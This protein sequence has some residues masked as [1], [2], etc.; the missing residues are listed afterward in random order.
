METNISAEVAFGI[1]ITRLIP[2]IETSP[3]ATLSPESGLP[4]DF[5]LPVVYTVTA[6]DGSTK[7]FTTTISPAPA[8]YLGKWSSSPIDFGLGLMR[9]NAELTAEGGITLEFVNIMTG[10]KDS[11]SLKGS[12]EP[13][14]RQNTEIKVDQTHRWMNNSWSEESCCRT[15]MY[16]VVNSQSI[17]LF[18]CICNPKIDWWFQVILTKQ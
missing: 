1:D 9:V 7:T 2:T 18:Y 5:S 12:F 14:S 17:K 16:Q 4:T 6:E 11:N 15:M 3:R 10:E 8:P 13:V